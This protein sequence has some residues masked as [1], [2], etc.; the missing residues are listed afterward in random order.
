MMILNVIFLPIPSPAT[1]VEGRCLPLQSLRFDPSLTLDFFF[2][3]LFFPSFEN[4]VGEDYDV[5]TFLCAPGGVGSVVFLA[6]KNL[7]DPY[8]SNGGRGGWRNLPSIA[9][10]SDS[11]TYAIRPP[12]SSRS[13]IRYPRR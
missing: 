9:T 6:F 4:G 8:C 1:R 2:L 5:L 10:Y 7:P 12:S 11:A 3:L 13:S